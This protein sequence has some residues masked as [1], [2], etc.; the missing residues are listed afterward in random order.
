MRALPALLA[1]VVLLSG[2]GGSAGDVLAIEVSG[3]PLRAKQILVVTVDGRGSCDRGKLR[4]IPTDE[5]TEA[6]GIADDAKPLAEA[7][8][9]YTTSRPGARQYVLRLP[10]GNVRWTEGRPG[11]PSALARAQLLAL[12]L[13]RTLCAGR[14]A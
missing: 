5:T 7:G 14:S 1:A 8:A 9:D 13:G 10:Q 12:R 4:E 2:C 6:R 11:I 3:G